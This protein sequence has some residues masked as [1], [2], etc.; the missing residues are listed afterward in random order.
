MAPFLQPEQVF[1]PGLS[2]AAAGAL[3]HL[4]DTL[5]R[6]CRPRDDDAGD[7]GVA[8]L[9]WREGRLQVT[10]ARARVL[11]SGVEWEPWPGGPAGAQGCYDM[12][13]CNHAAEMV[14][15]NLY[16][17]AA[18]FTHARALLSGRPGACVL[19]I[20]TDGKQVHK[21][22]EHWGGSP[23]VFEVCDGVE[24]LFG[25]EF[26]VP[27]GR[28]LAA[29]Q[30]NAF[31]LRLG[32]SEHAWR[33]AYAVRRN[34]CLRATKIA[35]LRPALDTDGHELMPT[36]SWN[37]QLWHYRTGEN[38]PVDVVQGLSEGGEDWHGLLSQFSVFAFEPS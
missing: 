11:R 37:A 12:V 29:N 36:S 18:F 20:C 21:R 2:E 4:R 16:A 15:T 26:G 14:W 7:L 25:V 13:L 30:S 24:M 33:W 9:E 19:G 35:G 31:G 6:T 34:D 10:D 23:A 17:G 8:V 27:T 1:G 32:G 38:W 3:R 22:L 28:W 5:V